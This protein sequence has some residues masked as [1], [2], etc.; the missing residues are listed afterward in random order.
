MLAKSKTSVPITPECYEFTYQ[1][2][3]FEDIFGPSPQISSFMTPVQRTIRQSIVKAKS[4]R[5]PNCVELCIT[6]KH[7]ETSDSLDSKLCELEGLRPDLTSINIVFKNLVK[8]DNQSPNRSNQYKHEI[9]LKGI[10]DHSLFN[11]IYLLMGFDEQV[12]SDF[13][14]KASTYLMGLFD[15]NREGK[16]RYDVIN[17][18]LYAIDFTK[19]SRISPETPFLIQSKESGPSFC[20]DGISRYAIGI[21]STRNECEKYKPYYGLEKNYTSVK[22]LIDDLMLDLFRSDYDCFDYKV[23]L[24]NHFDFNGENDVNISLRAQ[25]RFKIER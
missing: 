4:K 20:I 6:L 8:K 5:D 15:K 11:V 24:L 18:K 10:E 19:L 25:K 14:S 17:S 13:Y 16:T 22:S 12:Q 7:V 9:I 23:F 2:R 21:E 1:N 3:T